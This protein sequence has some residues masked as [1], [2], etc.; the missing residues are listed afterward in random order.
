MPGEHTAQ[1]SLAEDQHP[2]GSPRCGRSTRS[3]RRSSSPADTA[4]DLD[5]LDPRVR[6]HR[7]ERRPELPGPVAD[8]EPEPG[9]FAKVHDEVAVSIPSNREGS[10]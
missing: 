9:V 3:V 1:V 5:H 2:V 6:Q 4:A 10:D 8:E 7:V